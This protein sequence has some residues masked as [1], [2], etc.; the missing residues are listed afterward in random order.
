LIEEQFMPR[1]YL[2]GPVTA[3]F[4]EQN[5]REV[6]ASGDCIAFNPNGD[7]GLT[8]G[9]NDRWHDVV[10]RL[11]AGWRPDA[12]VLSLSYASVPDFLWAA[13]VPIIGLAANS[14]PTH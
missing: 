12:I 3:S 9:P 11:P 8:I 13:P 2:F 6:T 14:G 10:E 4:A 1:H 5:L 7:L